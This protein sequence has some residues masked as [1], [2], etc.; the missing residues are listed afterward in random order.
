MCASEQDAG[1]QREPPEPHTLSSPSARVLRPSSILLT[2]RPPRRRPPSGDQPSGDEW[3]PGG[4]VL[5]ATEPPLAAESLPGIASHPGEELLPDSGLLPDDEPRP[6]SAQVQT[7]DAASAGMQ[8]ARLPD[9]SLIIIG[10]ALFLGA[11]ATLTLTWAWSWHAGSRGTLTLSRMHAI[12]TSAMGELAQGASG[13]VASHCLWVDGTWTEAVLVT[14]AGC[15]LVGVGVAR[16][17]RAS[18]K[19]A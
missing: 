10:A 19:R 2:F 4:R 3:P 6:R 9:A 15:V 18:K 7:F 17:L 16:I 1:R 5:P 13:N 12:C 8:T 11:L 14:V